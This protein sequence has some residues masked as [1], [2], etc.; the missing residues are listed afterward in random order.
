MSTEVPP[1]GETELDVL[2][3]E[4]ACQLIVASIVEYPQHRI[5]P[6][7][8]VAD[9][10][11]KAYDGTSLQDVPITIADLGR[12]NPDPAI[13][14]PRVQRIPDAHGI[15]RQITPS[16]A[17]RFMV[18][19]ALMGL[20]ILGDSTLDVAAAEGITLPPLVHD[21]PIIDARP[22]KPG[23]TTLSRYN[24]TG[25]DALHDAL[26]GNALLAKGVGERIRTLS[27]PYRKDSSVQRARV[28]AR[29]S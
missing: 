18:A 4:R 14:Q 15:A 10:L 11:V 24:L 22:S 16:E 26:T 8:M 21:E 1:Y 6:A 23:D 9:E 27:A 5:G 19:Y 7:V 25:I 2:T 20:D 29:V 28:R 3:H 13:W 17:H 12:I